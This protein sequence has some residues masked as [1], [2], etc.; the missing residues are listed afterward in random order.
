VGVNKRGISMNTKS[1]INSS[2]IAP[3]GMNC[4]ICMAYL[5]EKKKCPGCYGSNEDKSVSVMKCIIK[6]CEIIKNNQSGFCFECEKYP[7]ARL[8]QLDKRYKTKY[9]MSM[10]ENLENIKNFGLKKFVTEERIRWAC[11][12]CGGIICVHRG[13]CYQ[14]GKRKK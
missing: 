2:L 7:C 6:N 8:K 4:G 3:C 5:R 9:A 1:Y 13:Y 10:I 14:C 12:E 11:S